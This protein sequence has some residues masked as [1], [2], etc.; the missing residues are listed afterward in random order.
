MSNKQNIIKALASGVPMTA[1]ELTTAIGHYDR[2]VVQTLISQINNNLAKKA[3]YA[4]MSDKPLGKHTR[5][6]L[7]S[8]T[9]DPVKFEAYVQKRGNRVKNGIARTKYTLAAGPQLL[10]PPNMQLLTTQIIG[11]IMQEITNKTTIPQIIQSP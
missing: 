4:I 7:I 1:D 11:G 6:S 10:T 9:T 8:Q 2:Y 3:E 5:Y